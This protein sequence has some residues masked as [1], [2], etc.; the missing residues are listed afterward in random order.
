MTPL[1]AVAREL[2]R[3]RSPLVGAVLGRS[4]VLRGA[5]ADPHTR[6][7]LGAV[8]ALVVALTTSL[9]APTLA[10]LWAPLVLGIPHVLADVR[11][12]LLNPYRRI[13]LRPRDALVVASLVAFAVIEAPQLGAIVVIGAALLTPARRAL[14]PGRNA[15]MPAVHA[16]TP[17]THALTPSTHALTPSTHALTP[18]THA[19]TPSTHALTPSTHALTPS[20]VAQRRAAVLAAA[21]ALACAAWSSPVITSYAIMHAHNVVA[22]AVLV[23]LARHRRTAWALTGA[24]L[25]TTAVILTGALDAVL[26]MRALDQL[27]GYVLPD[28]AFDA[29]PTAACAR[30]ALTFVFL[31]GVH[32]AVWLRLIPAVVRPHRGMRG[33]GASVRALER[34][35]TIP[36][37]AIVAAAALALPAMAIL[38]ATDAATLRDLYVRLAGGHAY[39]ELAVLARWLS[40]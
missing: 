39:L 15:M 22:L 31:Q 11:Y 20:R 25:A 12:L 29:W 30:V 7:A 32:Y 16:L 6:L 23:A 21:I 27:S 5:I 3:V 33:F 35:C 2:D 34:D 14:M 40:S 4:A 37:T 8:L 38:G 13:A 24:A 26:P 9:A 36:I 19:L 1:A 28:A 10:F 17:S 18:S